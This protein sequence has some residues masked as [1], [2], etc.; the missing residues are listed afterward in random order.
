MLKVK[1]GPL[2]GVTLSL[3]SGALSHLLTGPGISGAEKFVSS[4]ECV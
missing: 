2:F 3:V 4:S 1:Q